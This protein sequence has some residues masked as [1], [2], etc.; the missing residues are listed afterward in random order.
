MSLRHRYAQGVA[1]ML[2]NCA[3]AMLSLTANA[4]SC[5][6]QSQMTAAER[7]ALASA[8]RIMVAEVQS[9]DVLALRQ[10]TIPAVAA[11]CGIGQH[12]KATCAAGLHYRR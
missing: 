1:F 10:N 4:A 12:I 6:T 9:G 7:D 11:D 5:K 3:G 2:L 8:A